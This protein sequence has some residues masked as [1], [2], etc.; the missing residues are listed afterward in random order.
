M[1]EKRIVL[2]NHTLTTLL[3]VNAGSLK[4]FL[5]PTVTKQQTVK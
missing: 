3:V 1:I 5:G 2:I 4:V